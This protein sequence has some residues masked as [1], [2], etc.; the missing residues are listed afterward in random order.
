MANYSVGIASLS[1]VHM[2]PSFLYF[3]TTLSPSLLGSVW[4]PPSIDRSP[5]K[6]WVLVGVADMRQ[7][8]SV[9]RMREKMVNMQQ[10]AIREQEA[11]RQALQEAQSQQALD[12]RVQDA[13]ARARDLQ[14]QLE[15]SQGAYQEL[16]QSLQTS[17]QSLQTTQQ[18][19]LTTQQSLQRT[20]ADKQALERALQQSQVRERALQKRVTTAEQ[21][22]REQVQVLQQSVTQAN[23]QVEH[24]QRRLEEAENR[25]EEAERRAHEGRQE[26][27]ETE[28]DPSWV[29]RRDEI[30][31][32]D[33]ELGRGGWAVVKVAKFRATRVAAKCLHGQIVSNY[34]RLLFIREMN[35]AARV[36]HPNLLQFI[37]ATLRGELII[38]TELMP[39]SIRRELENECTFSPKQ[40]TS[41]SLDVARALNYLHLMHPDPIIHRDISSAN[42]LLEPNS[43]RAKVSDYGSVNLLQ[44]LRTVTPGN[45]TYAAPE[46]ED[47]TLQSP[48]MDIFS[49][50]VLL[51][52]MCTAHFPEVADREHLIP[53]I[54][55][56]DMVALIRRCLAEERNVR[57][58]ASDIITEL[59]ETHNT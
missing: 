7:L 6:E 5:T 45:P 40:L 17:E 27:R 55:H 56:P 49:F 30:I 3:I 41:I 8:G 11:G 21:E 13:E 38:L 51:V 34:N 59:S 20:Q 4:S 39:T 25:A 58:S 12:Q 14:T 22:A 16:L 15:A 44:R 2:P 52:E 53:S 32:T 36:R 1:V 57:P 31:F 29:V 54:Q 19:L 10:R 18:S 35:M 33:E 46:A 43:W 47:A 42:V 48:K 26:E 9:Q 28:S 24:L 50:G 37:G 23:T